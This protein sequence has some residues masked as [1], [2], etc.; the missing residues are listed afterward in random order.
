[1]LRYSTTRRHV[2]VDLN[3]TIPRRHS[4]AIYNLSIALLRLTFLPPTVSSTSAA[5]GPFHQPLTRSF[6]RQ[7]PQTRTQIRTGRS[8]EP[9]LKH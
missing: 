6:R 5:H 1:M 3:N 9:M 2:H 4:N 7:D 8:P